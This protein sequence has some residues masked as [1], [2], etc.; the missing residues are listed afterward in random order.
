MTATARIGTDEVRPRV[1]SFLGV[2]GYSVR[3]IT[4][5][6]LLAT[7]LVIVAAA[8]CWK[9]DSDALREQRVQFSRDALLPMAALLRENRDLIQE[10]Q[11]GPTMEH[12]SDLLESYLAMIRQDGV[13]KHGDMKQRLDQLAENNAA[14][15]TLIKAYAS[16]AK[17]PAFT[18]EADEFRNYASTWRDRWNSVMEIFMAGGNYPVTEIPFPTGFLVATDAEIA[19]MR[20]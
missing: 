1:A 2:S 13:A 20:Y 15:V 6:V 7:S 4:M 10:L 12:G 16:H 14:I 17:T 11:T 9:I 19:A 3:I 5:G 18:A 8:V